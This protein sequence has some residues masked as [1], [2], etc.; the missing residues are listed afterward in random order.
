MQLSARAL[1]IGRLA[2][3]PDRTSAAMAATDAAEPE[4]FNMIP[5]AKL[6][7]Q[8]NRHETVGMGGKF[9]G[10]GVLLRS[11]FGTGTCGPWPGER[12]RHC[13]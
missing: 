8:I 4:I 12:H 5:S 3:I 7:Q 13:F 1:S 2:P 6:Q 11:N 10:P 9:G